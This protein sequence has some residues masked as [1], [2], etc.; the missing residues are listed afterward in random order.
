MLLVEAELL[1]GQG[2]RV[3]VV[4]MRFVKPLDRRL[5]QSV[6]TRIPT[7]V[8]VEDN[9]IQ[10]GFGAAVLEELQQ[11]G[12]TH[13]GVKLHGLPDGFVDHGTPEELYRMLRLDGQGIAEVTK[14]FLESRAE[15]GSARLVEL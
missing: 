11:I 4:N 8:T 1:E 7:I 14:A 13:V 10:G 3:E 2:F 9:V 12:M 15:Q 6:A 5:V